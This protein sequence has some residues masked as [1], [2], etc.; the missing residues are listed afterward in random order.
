[1]KLKPRKEL[2]L[3]LLA[4]AISYYKIKTSS[5]DPSD[6]LEWEC[7]SHPSLELHECNWRARLPGG[8]KCTYCDHVVGKPCPISCDFQVFCLAV[9]AWR[10]GVGGPD[11]DEALRHNLYDLSSEELYMEVVK[12]FSDGSD[13]DDFLADGQQ[14]DEQE[15]VMGETEMNEF[16]NEKTEERAEELLSIKEAAQWYGCTYANI[17]NY[18][19][20]GRLPSVAKGR[21]MFVKRADLEEFKSRPRTRKSKNTE[22]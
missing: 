7:F 17:Y 16:L 11:F 15:N 19:K 22:E 18:V 20:E 3:E 12:R 6:L 14:G 4:K 13:V 21:R 9:F 5:P 1:M 8:H 2:T 10:L